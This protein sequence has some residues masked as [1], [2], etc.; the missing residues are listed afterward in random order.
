MPFTEESNRRSLSASEIVELN[1]QYVVV[2]DD[3][4]VNS[5]QGCCGILFRV[6]HFNVRFGS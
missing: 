1:L 2:V 4:S 3:D 6:A 5:I